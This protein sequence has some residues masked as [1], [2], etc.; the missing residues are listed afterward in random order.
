M[1][2]CIND[3]HPHESCCHSLFIIL[4]M[5]VIYILYVSMDI[6]LLI[7]SHLLMIPLYGYTVVY[8][9]DLSSMGF[10]VV[11]GFGPDEQ[12]GPRQTFNRK[13]HGDMS[14]GCGP[15]SGRLHHMAGTSPPSP[16]WCPE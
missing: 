2:S 3:I 1:P 14:L 5:W 10:C 6:I 16:N 11:S 8:S 15:R 4:D 12:T 7:Y 9:R 13:T